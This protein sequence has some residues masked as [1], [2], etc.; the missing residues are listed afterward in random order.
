[1]SNEKIWLIDMGDEITW[2]DSP[3]PAPD[4]DYDDSTGYIRIDIYNKDVM[5]QQ[6]QITEL[7]GRLKRADKTI[8][9][10]RDAL[11]EAAGEIDGLVGF[12]DVSE[13]YRELVA[14]VKNAN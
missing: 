8:E 2:C 5:E 9:R 10:L 3:S 7:Q 11:L 13:K 4:I 14:E 6:K 1:M 12:N